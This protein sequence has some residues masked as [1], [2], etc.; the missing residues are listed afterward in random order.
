[1]TRQVVKSAKGCELCEKLWRRLVAFKVKLNKYEKYASIF[2]KKKILKNIE[3]MPAAMGVKIYEYI[4]KWSRKSCKVE[5]FWESMKVHSVTACN[6]TWVEAAW[7]KFIIDA[8]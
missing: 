6:K 7:A 8:W 4:V 2:Y 1:M 5:K 3:R